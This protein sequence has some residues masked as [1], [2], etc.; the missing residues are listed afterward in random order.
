MM[1]FGQNDKG[2]RSTHFQYPKGLSHFPASC[3][4]RPANI[5]GKRTSEENDTMTFDPY[6]PAAA[7]TVFKDASPALSGVQQVKDWLKSADLS[8]YTRDDY[9]RAVEKFGRVYDNRTD[10]L[11][12]DTERVERILKMRGFD[13]DHFRTVKAYTRW[14]GKV[15]AAFRGASG[16]LAARR[17][18]LAQDD[19]WAAF[20]AALRQHA[21]C[22][23][24]GPIDTIHP[25]SITSIKVMA[26]LARR[27]NLGPREIT[28]HVGL[29]LYLEDAR[30]EQRRSIE[31]GLRW[32]DALREV[33]WGDFSRW[34]PSNAIGFQKPVQVVH[35][36]P[37][38]DH[39][40]QE[41][42]SMVA[43]ATR[44]RIDQTTNE[45]FGDLN[46][47][48]IHYA[49]KK[50]I[51]TGMLVC[52]RTAAQV[53]TVAGFFD[54][55]SITGV[56]TCWQRWDSDGD[57]R[58]ISAL[59][60]AGYFQ[61]L[62]PFLERNGY[63][64]QAVRDALKETRWLQQGLDSLNDMTPA[65]RE[66]CKR[67]LDERLLRLRFLSLHIRWR[68]LAMKELA[69]AKS[70]PGQRGK[71]HIERARAFGVCAA[72][73]A[74][75]TDAAPIRIGNALD[76]TVNI[77]GAWLSL[78]TR[79]RTFARLEIPAGETKNGQ[80]ISGKMLAESPL[81]GLPTL[82]WYMKE[83]RPLF[84]GFASSPYLFPAIRDPDKP[85]SYSTF[86][87]WWWRAISEADLPDLNPHRFRHGQ[88]SI[89]VARNPGNW[90]LVSVRLG[91]TEKTAKGN[92]A[93]VDRARIMEE[94]MNS[95]A[96][97]FSG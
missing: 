69:K 33:A 2:P 22:P 18:L 17:E 83:I 49:A 16:E 36:A 79:Y 96:K 1:S 30:K 89:L 8:A 52:G 46:P 38:P 19:D 63:S 47:H 12:L 82:L 61:R 84:Q 31:K 91:D 6:S 45:T 74:I 90:L 13:P 27:R 97:E 15:M 65:A 73:A 20:L 23:L 55:S 59:T 5:N 43:I 67:I 34:L 21:S 80:P 75:E 77:P 68:K 41:L 93:F 50:V 62:A 10:P 72:F 54:R 88:A 70:K 32:M 24:E 51:D 76:I 48:P 3:T 56:L 86:S 71:R 9:R 28:P 58:A 81:K 57:P 14:A 35:A 78:P 25:N 85:L 40:K 39:L 37:L 94:G 29:L 60:A 11:P 7:A 26:T 4:P 64:G 44:G 95:L 66:F 53:D 42:D 92:Y 87:N